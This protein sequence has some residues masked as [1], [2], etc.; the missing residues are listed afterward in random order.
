MNAP[1]N[2][3]EWTAED[4]RMRKILAA[5]GLTGSAIAEELGRTRAGS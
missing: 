1:L 2:G 4:V 5:Q 3:K